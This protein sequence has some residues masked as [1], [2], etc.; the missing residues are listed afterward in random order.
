MDFFLWADVYQGPGSSS[1]RILGFSDCLW[2]WASCP[3]SGRITPA[4]W[5]GRGGDGFLY[6]KIPPPTFEVLSKRVLTSPD[7]TVLSSLESGFLGFWL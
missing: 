7:S 1:E 3:Q 2:V 6:V 5:V 4:L